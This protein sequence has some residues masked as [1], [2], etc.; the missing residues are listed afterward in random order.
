MAL[1]WV[2]GLREWVSTLNP[3]PALLLLLVP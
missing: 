1:K 3:Y 2:R